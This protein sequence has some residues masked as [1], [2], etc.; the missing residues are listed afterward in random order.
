MIL[1]RLNHRESYSS[2]PGLKKILDI[3]NEL[4][5]ETLS[6]ERI[7]IDEDHIF[8]NPVSLTTKPKSECI[9]EAH[10]KY[11]DIH[12]I[13][14]GTEEIIVSD[15]SDLSIVKPYSEESDVGFYKGM[16][17]TACIL[18][19]GDFLVCFPQDAHKVAIAADGNCREV[20]KAVGKIKII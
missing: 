18:N 2:I 8:I 15:I 17:G 1:D 3:L 16:H 6:K 4:T 13:L 14:S 20:I 5:A 11:A 7:V 19:P 12:C 9:F 10:R